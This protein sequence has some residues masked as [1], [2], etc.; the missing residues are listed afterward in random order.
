MKDHSAMLEAHVQFE[1]QRLNAD[2][3]K[4]TL[5]EEIASIF[6][7]LEQVKIQ[8]VVHEA[9]VS[10]WITR[11]VV[12]MPL[13]AEVSDFI[14]EN[15]IIAFEFLQ[16]DK[17]R[18]DEILPRQLFDQSAVSLMGLS[19]LRREVI[20][21]IVASSA[22][23]MLITHVLY[24]GIKGF[25]LTENSFTKNVPGVSS[26]LRLGK[27]ALNTAAL[28]MEMNI[29]EQLI[30]FINGNIKET[31]SDSEKFL[32]EALDDKSMHQLADEIWAANASSEMSKV[33][34]Y[35]DS[36]AIQG[37]SEAV[38]AFWLHYRTTALFRELVEGVVHSFF[39]R[40]GRKSVGAFLATV[41]V[42]Q[43]MIAQEVHTF[44]IP[45]MEKALA[46][47]YLEQ[48]IRRRLGAF[49]AVY[50]PQDG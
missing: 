34:G 12:E 43:A 45:V 18:V 3:L 44:A 27:Q 16:E 17:T 39:R 49:Y 2:N 35:F 36:R 10:D 8:E 32:D 46:S 30:A 37:V 20:R 28:K 47:N 23:S 48:S 40:Y 9:Q 22:Y 29:D 4:G 42:T 14:T 25:V 19:A 33:A 6:G 31:V 38:Q 15:V 11:N 41:G 1:M 21:Q 26:L 5:D 7:W 13:S 50:E 24:H